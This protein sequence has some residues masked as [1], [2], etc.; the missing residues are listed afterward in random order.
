MH[1]IQQTNCGASF[2]LHNHKDM[3]TRAFLQHQ[4]VYVG[5]HADSGLVSQ[6]SIQHPHSIF[7]NIEPTDQ[8]RWRSFIFD[9]LSAAVCIKSYCM[10]ALNE[11]QTKDSN[12]LI[13][14]AVALRVDSRVTRG[15][16]SR[17]SHR[18]R[19]NANGR[20]ISE[21]YFRV[22]QGVLW[23]PS[24]LLCCSLMSCLSF[25]FLI[26]FEGN[27]FLEQSDKHYLLSFGLALFSFPFYCLFDDGQTFVKLLFQ[28]PSNRVLKNETP[29]ERRNWAKLTHQMWCPHL[30]GVKDI[31]D[32]VFLVHVTMLF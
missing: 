3:P 17:I 23:L 4:S 2:P 5:A 24:L 14:F 7:Q 31:W 22:S 20:F 10:V 29:F 32:F 6:G 8:H 28:L 13:L 12:R 16:Y 21:I 1:L 27:F 18:C 26:S 30:N 11:S 25:L 9:F 15:I 19:L